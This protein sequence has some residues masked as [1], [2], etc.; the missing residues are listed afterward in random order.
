MTRIAGVYVTGI[1]QDLANAWRE[2]LLFHGVQRVTVHDRP[3][4]QR[5]HIQFHR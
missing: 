5:Y 4:L 2:F 3:D 1:P